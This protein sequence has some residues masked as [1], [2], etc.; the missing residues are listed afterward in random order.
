M[1]EKPLENEQDLNIKIKVT[2]DMVEEAR[3]LAAKE[4]SNEYKIIEQEVQKIIIDSKYCLVVESTYA[5]DYDTP[6]EAYG[7]QEYIYEI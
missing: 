4:I 2:D 5:V 7:C 1:K 6:I 3:D